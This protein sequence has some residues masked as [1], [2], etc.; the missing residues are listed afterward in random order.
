[1]LRRVDATMN[2]NLSIHHSLQSLALLL[3]ATLCPVRLLAL[4]RAVPHL[5]SRN[6]KDAWRRCGSE[7]ISS[8][9]NNEVGG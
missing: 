4:D 6:A 7:C 3:V 2:G 5:R 9:T 1:V 8:A